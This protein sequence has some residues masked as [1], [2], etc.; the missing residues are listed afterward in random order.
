MRD[1]IEKF[2]KANVQPFGVNPAGIESHGRYAKRF[3]FPFPLLSD[4]ER[5]VAAAYGALRMFGR[6]IYRS[7]VLIGQDGRVRFASR[8]APPADE[9][10]AVL[11][12]A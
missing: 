8:G 7:V 4:T 10:L 5:E 6:M 12:E 2:R 11:V 1:D 9:V 3:G